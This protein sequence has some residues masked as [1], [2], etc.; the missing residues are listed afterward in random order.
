METKQI[1]RQFISTLNV[2]LDNKTGFIYRWII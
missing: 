1:L 2:L